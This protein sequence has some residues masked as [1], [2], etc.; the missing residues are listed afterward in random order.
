VQMDIQI[1]GAVNDGRHIY[2]TISSAWYKTDYHRNA[3]LSQG[4]R[5]VT[6]AREAFPNARPVMYL[7]QPPR[8]VQALTPNDHQAIGN[9][10][11][12]TRWL[13]HKIE[14]ELRIATTVRTIAR[15][16]LNDLSLV[17]QVT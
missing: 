10:I 14:A 5:A 17:S 4:M 13:L 6:L 3:S 15:A 12:T 7:L 11:E 1:A 2:G 16:I 8:T 9:D